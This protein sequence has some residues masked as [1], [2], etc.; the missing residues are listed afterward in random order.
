MSDE[1]DY[2]KY[3]HFIKILVI[4]D[5]EV[6]KTSYIKRFLVGD[7]SNKPIDPKDPKKLEETKKLL[8]IDGQKIYFNIWDGLKNTKQNKTTKTELSVRVQGIII[9]YDVSNYTSFSSLEYYIKEVKEACGSDMPVII[10]GNKT[11]L[12]R[13]VGEDEGENFAKNNNVEFIET[14]V[15]DNVNIQKCIIQLGQK[16]IKSSYFKGDTI[17]INEAKFKKKKRK[18]I[19]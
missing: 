4:G 1:M 7:F 3:D 12:E 14:S 17:T 11:D 10:V 18:K 6:G 9:M 13:V 2:S 8:E 16:I 5:S 19:C 15:A